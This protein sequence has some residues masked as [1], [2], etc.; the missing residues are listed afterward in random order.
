MQK[1]SLTLIAKTGQRA[2][3][4]VHGAKVTRPEPAA[5]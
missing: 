1:I 3:F 2:R 4:A 5:A